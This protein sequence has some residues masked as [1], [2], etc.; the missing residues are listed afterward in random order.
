M[1]RG[2]LLHG[3]PLP[4]WLCQ[5][6]GRTLWYRGAGP[7]GAPALECRV[8]PYLPS[9]SNG[10]GAAVD[11]AGMEARMAAVNA[12][13]YTPKTE[14]SKP[15][16]TFSLKISRVNFPSPRPPFDSS[17]QPP[18]VTPYIRRRPT[19]TGPELTLQNAP[20]GRVICDPLGWAPTRNN[21]SLGGSVSLRGTPSNN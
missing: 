15:R 14:P 21:G 19:E 1:A 9:G 3:E 17:S 8:G 12:P 4:G 13:D 10:R 2:I 16:F 11:H 18:I 7:H 20:Q 5:C 6:P